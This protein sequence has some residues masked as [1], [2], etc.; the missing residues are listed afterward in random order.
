MAPSM[1]TTLPTELWMS[2]QE[3]GPCRIAQLQLL[4]TLYNVR[5]SG[6]VGRR[7]QLTPSRTLI[8]LP[9]TSLFT[10]F[11]A[12]ASFKLFVPF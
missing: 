8:L 10:G 4:A 9:E 12:P 11:E 6:G 2:S 5:K 7:H 1:A 3:N